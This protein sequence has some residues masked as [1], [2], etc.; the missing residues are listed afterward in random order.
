MMIETARSKNLG[1]DGSKS[2]LEGIRGHQG[3]SRKDGGPWVRQAG[4]SGGDAQIK[5]GLSKAKTGSSGGTAVDQVTPSHEEP[6]GTKPGL[7]MSAPA[8]GAGWQHVWVL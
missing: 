2:G 6:G 7:G 3:P 4:A 1:T 8:R 5:G